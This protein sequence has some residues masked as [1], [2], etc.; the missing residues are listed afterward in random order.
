M[1][2]P[3]AGKP[4]AEAAEAHGVDPQG[5][6]DTLVADVQAEIDEKVAD[7]SISAEKAAEWSAGIQ[8]RITNYV[9]GGSEE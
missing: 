4:I 5:I 3:G 7:G 9:N 8:E 2:E 6:V 1:G